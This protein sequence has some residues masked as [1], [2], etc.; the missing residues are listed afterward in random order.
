VGPWLLEMA[1]ITKIAHWRVLMLLPKELSFSLKKTS[2]KSPSIKLED[3]NHKDE[4]D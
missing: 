4:K 1:I 3:L 2:V